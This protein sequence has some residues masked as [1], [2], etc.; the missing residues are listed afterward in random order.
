MQEANHRVKNRLQMVAGVLTLHRRDADPKARAQFDDARQ[1]VLTV[2]RVHERLYKGN[3][4]ET[5]DFGTFLRELCNDLHNA[6]GSGNR[7]LVCSADPILLPTAVAIPVALIVN[8]LITNAIKY[9]YGPTDVGEIRVRCARAEAA[10][11]LTVTDEG[12]A[13]AADFSVAGN[14]GLGLR[15]VDMLL[16]Q[17]QGRLTVEAHGRGKTFRADVPLP[18]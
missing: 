5:V 6:L 7:T 12:A 17:L 14:A 3:S 13:L 2:A 8:E 1:Q 9:A 16:H 18:P 11:V 15:M 10:L 4:V